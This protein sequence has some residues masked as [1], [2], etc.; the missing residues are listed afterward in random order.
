MLVL[1]RFDSN[2]TVCYKKKMVQS[3][4]IFLNMKCFQQQY[5]S[6]RNKCS[7][8]CYLNH[9]FSFCKSRVMPCFMRWGKFP[10]V[11]LFIFILEIVMKV[12]NNEAVFL[13]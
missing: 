8:C 1:L 5:I 10:F 6:K 9:I 12:S 7:F 13:V 2:Y 11:P 3:E 4:N